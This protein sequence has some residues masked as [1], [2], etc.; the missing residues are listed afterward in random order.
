[1]IYRLKPSLDFFKDF[2]DIFI[3]GQNIQYGLIETIKQKTCIDFISLF[4]LSL[5]DIIPTRF[6]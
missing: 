3:F 6:F 5:L 2:V 4:V 1:M